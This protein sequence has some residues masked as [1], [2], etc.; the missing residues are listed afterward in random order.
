[1]G[2]EGQLCS[3]AGVPCST[4][5]SAGASQVS[6]G[7]KCVKVSPD[8]L[9]LQGEEFVLSEALMETPTY[10]GGPSLPLT[11]GGPVPMAVPCLVLGSRVVL[12]LGLLII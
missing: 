2:W 7:S 5:S 4:D 1:M 11:W 10:R 6:C 9:R 12:L 3:Q 8:L